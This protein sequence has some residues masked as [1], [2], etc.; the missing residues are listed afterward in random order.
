MKQHFV[1][2]IIS[3]LIFSGCST[4]KSKIAPK[5]T[6]N[7]N[8][9]AAISIAFT[10]CDQSFFKKLG[11]TEFY[12][13]RHSEEFSSAWDKMLELTAN[14]SNKRDT[15]LTLVNYLGSK[16]VEV[17][18]TM[19]V[20]KILNTNDHKLLNSFMDSKVIPFSILKGTEQYLKSIKQRLKHKKDFLFFDKYKITSNSLDVFF[21]KMEI[22]YTQLKLSQSN[23]AILS[24]EEWIIGKKYYV[25]GFLEDVQGRI[26]KERTSESI[27]SEDLI[28]SKCSLN[29]TRRY[30]VLDNDNSWLKLKATQDQYEETLTI[31]EPFYV[32]RADVTTPY[33]VSDGIFEIAIGEHDAM[34]FSFV[35]DTMVVTGGNSA[36]DITEDIMPF[37]S[38]VPYVKDNIDRD[39]SEYK[40]LLPIGFKKENAFY[41]KNFI[42][43]FQDDRCE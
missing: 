8:D 39:V 4:P 6:L 30:Q 13:I 11:E 35:D 15:C 32:D 21:K 7:E 10:K 14:T 38:N 27:D 12:Q 29:K 40:Y 24:K 26:S 33:V 16:N 23:I 25:C 37:L 43:T 18:D 41:R 22:F 5:K 36:C 20:F 28:L 19:I 9:I 2:L 1:I 34:K 31:D 17:S 42:G 3:I